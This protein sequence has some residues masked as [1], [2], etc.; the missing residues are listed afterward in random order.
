MY[1]RINSPEFIKMEV[2]MLK[3]ASETGDFVIVRQLVDK[4]PPWYIDEAFIIASAYGHLPIAQFLIQHGANVHA[5]NDRA[6]RS[7]KYYRNNTEIVEYIEYIIYV[8]DAITQSNYEEIRRVAK[9]Y[10]DDNETSIYSDYTLPIFKAASMDVLQFL[11]NSFYYQAGF[12]QTEDIEKVLGKLTSPEKEAYLNRVLTDITPYVDIQQFDDIIPYDFPDSPEGCIDSAIDLGGTTGATLVRCGRG[13]YVMKQA[14]VITKSGFIYN[15][16]L[17]NQIYRLLGVDVPDVRFYTSRNTAMLLSKYIEDA[18]PFLPTDI[19]VVEKTRQGFVADAFLA[20]WDVLGRV[21]DN[22]LVKEGVPY[23]VDNG[24]ALFFRAQGAMKPVG[25]FSNVVVELDT[26]R[27]MYP[28]GS[29]NTVF[30][31]LTNDDIYKQIAFYVPKIEND[32]MP[33]IKSE[34]LRRVLGERLEYLKTWSTQRSVAPT[35]SPKAKRIGDEITT[36][37]KFFKRQMAYLATLPLATRQLVGEYIQL[38]QATDINDLLCSEGVEGLLLYQYRVYTMLMNAFY[39]V[40]PIHRTLIVYRGIAV[41]VDEFN[42]KQLTCQ[43]VSTSTSKDIATSNFAYD[44]SGSVVLKIAIQPGS[45]VLPLYG[46]FKDTTLTSYEENRETF[47]REMEVL[48]P[49][50]GTWVRGVSKTEG[51]ITYIYYTYSDRLV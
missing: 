49:P 19:S 6:L 8:I 42:E 17:A 31:T 1:S 33:R 51:S 29:N 30:G 9:D 13:D 20:N 24:G 41:S 45:K 35:I 5:Q 48:L 46:Y 34:I 43:F 3:R 47:D 21:Y 32:V 11:I 7:A 40:P 26:M 28:G 22:V 50:N 36:Y 27:T 12:I 25:Q 10:Y 37:T 39:G 18:D 16:Y 44:P 23:R 2:D 15:E 4:V 38:Q 14:E